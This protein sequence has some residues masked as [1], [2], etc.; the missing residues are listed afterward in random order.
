MKRNSSGFTLAELAIVMAIVGLLLGGMLSVL[1]TQIE[2]RQSTETQKTLELARDALIGYAVANGRLPC[3]AMVVKVSNVDTYTGVEQLTGAACTAAFYGYY[4]AVTVGLTPTDAQGYL[5]D[6]WGNRIRYAVTTVNSSAFS[7]T[8]TASQMK[9]VGLSSLSP[10]LR[11]CSTATNMTT[12]ST[13]ACD[14][15]KSLTTNAVA[16]ILSL[17]RNAATGGTG[18]DEVHNAK[19][20]PPDSPSSY[21]D[22]AF[23]YHTPE[24][25]GAANGEFDDLVTWL[26][27]NV[28]YNRLVA[29]GAI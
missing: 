17:G 19:I 25:A 15:N 6:A 22:R 28:L 20:G 7:T 4:P 9:A 29:A 11:V 13:A 24:P 14:T 5:I 18:I 8:T 21:N 12:G 16:V 27:P 3:P 10:D 1:S 2:Q 26:S 23:V